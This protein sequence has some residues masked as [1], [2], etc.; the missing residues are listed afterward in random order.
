MPLTICSIVNSAIS[1]PDM[2]DDEIEIRNRLTG[3]Q[4]ER[5]EAAQ[6]IEIAVADQAERDGEHDQPRHDLDDQARAAV[7]RLRD[8]GQIEM[9]VAAGR[10]RGAD[11]DRVD[12]HRGGGFLQ[13]Q[14]GMADGAGDD[15][16]GDRHR[17]AEA[18]DAA[19]DHQHGLEPVE[20]PPFQMTLPL[21]HQFVGECHR[22]RCPVECCCFHPPLEGRVADAAQQT[23][24]GWGRI[25]PQ[26]HPT[27]LDVRFAK[28]TLPSRGG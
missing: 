8:R 22:P 10:D 12:E 20:R 16:G 27:P 15:V 23:R 9:V 1:T 13:P 7:H 11:E 6:I 3:R 4:A 2:R 26:M 28:A 21:Q 14:P 19:Q 5:A 25:L 24:A 18:E 17:K